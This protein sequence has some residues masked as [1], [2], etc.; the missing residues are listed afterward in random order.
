MLTLVLVSNHQE[1]PM[2]ENIETITLTGKDETDLNR[3]QW[4]WQTGGSIDVV[5]VKQHPDQLLPMVMRARRPFAKIEMT[6]DRFSRRIDYYRRNRPPN[7]L[8]YAP[9]SGPAPALPLH[10]S[11]RRR[12]TGWQVIRPDACTI[13]LAT[14]S[15]SPASRTGRRV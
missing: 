5:I 4:D 3:K 1:N 12:G 10:R 8:A 9:A 6:D 2:S 15:L 13:G 7:A 11:Q 14:L